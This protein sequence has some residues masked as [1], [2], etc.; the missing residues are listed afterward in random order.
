MTNPKTLVLLDSYFIGG[1]FF[2]HSQNSNLIS[3]P[4]FS[5]D[6]G[7]SMHYHVAFFA[8]KDVPAGEELRF[9]YGYHVSAVRNGYSV[10]AW[11]EKRG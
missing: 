11:F 7:T 6:V 8:S 4:V 10:P 2:N 1:R 9:D 5:A 3:Q